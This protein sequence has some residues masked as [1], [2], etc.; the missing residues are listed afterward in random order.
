MS[1]AGGL[2]RGLAS[3]IPDSALTGVVLDQEPPAFRVVPIDEI[4]ANPE[5]PRTNFAR[6]ALEGLAESLRNHGMLSPL[7]VRRQ[8][9]QYVLIAGER[10]LRAAGLAGLNEVPVI[11]RESHEGSEQLELA[12]VENLQRED[13][14]P[15]ESALGFQRLIEEYGYTQEQ[16]A[17]R[18]GK[19]RA[20][21]A[22]A[23]RLLRLPENI[24]LA[25]RQG[26]ISAG[27]ARA[28]LP[29]GD[30]RKLERLLLRIIAQQLSVRATEAL[31]AR[32]I[33]ETASRSGRRQQNDGRMDYAN[34]LLSEVL[35]TSVSIR[36]R[37][38]GGG[39][40]VIEYADSEDLERLIHFIRSKD[41]I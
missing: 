10:R 18:V 25:V 40:I 28:M 19:K 26:R 8:E 38:R 22:N 11:L 23:I 7:I 34:Q 35:H 12:L 17:V 36:P 39:R 30:E 5:Q 32:L 21:V 16:V 37:Q 9:G 1:R 41:S 3:L 2:G 6:E 14:D 31:V 29:I 15:I 24:L 13:L 27:H 33:H 4:R 20:T